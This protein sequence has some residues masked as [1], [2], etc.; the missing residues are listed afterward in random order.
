MKTFVILL[1]TIALVSCADEKTFQVDGT[2]YV[3]VEPYGWANPEMKMDSVQ[4]KVC[5]VNVVWSCILFETIVAPV[6]LTG[7][8]LYE[9]IKLNPAPKSSNSTIDETIKIN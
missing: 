7:W 4:Y 6:L 9:P 5:V 2:H 1:L 3:V 8:Y